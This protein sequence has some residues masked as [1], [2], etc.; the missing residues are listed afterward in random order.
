MSVY[1]GLM[2]TTSEIQGIFD[3]V[4]FERVQPD[5]PAEDHLRDFQFALDNTVFADETV[6]PALEPVFDI[7]AMSTPANAFVI[8]HLVSMM[9]PEHCYVNI[10][11]WH[12][13]SFFS[14]CSVRDRWSIGVD[15]F[16]E[17]GGP[18]EEFLASYQESFEHERTRFFDMDYRDFF[19]N[20]MAAIDRKIGLYFY[21]G[22]H[23]YAAQY[24]ALKEA[25]P[26]LADNAVIL[27]DDTNL[28]SARKATLNWITERHPEYVITFDTLTAHEGHPTYWNGLMIFQLEGRNVLA[29][30]Q[31]RRAA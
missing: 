16:S 24:D 7:R 12:G 17:F 3:G 30:S 31:T 19:A 21:D 23:D 13:F 11:T 2:T 15:N 8:H 5:D 29:K 27:V 4:S 10:G 1:S 14:G 18:R 22:A 20:E 6:L 25:E 28:R 26:F 9:D